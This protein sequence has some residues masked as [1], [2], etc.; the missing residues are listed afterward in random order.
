MIKEELIE[1]IIAEFIA[2]GGCTYF[3]RIRERDQLNNDPR[4]LIHW[5]NE[6]EIT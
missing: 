5:A 2:M 6:L 1:L 3:D 4:Y